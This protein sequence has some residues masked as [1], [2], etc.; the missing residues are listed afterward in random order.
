MTRAILSERQSFG[1]FL[2]I[3]ALALL[4]WQLVLRLNLRH[5][6]KGRHGLRRWHFRAMIDVAVLGL[7]H[8]VLNSALIGVLIH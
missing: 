4:F 1:L 2:A 3:G 5:P 8:L 6:T 7:G